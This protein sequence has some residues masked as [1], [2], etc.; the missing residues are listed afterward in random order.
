M[1]G[2]TL[3]QKLFSIKYLQLNFKKKDMKKRTYIAPQIEQIKFDNEISLALE[4]VPA[5]GPG[6][7]LL[8]TPEY[9]NNDPFKNSIG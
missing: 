1:E 4:S 8:Q 9:L 3:Q 6:E 5:S 7:T 2:N